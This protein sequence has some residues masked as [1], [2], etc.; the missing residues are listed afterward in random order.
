MSAFREKK[1]TGTYHLENFP[2]A[3]NFFWG[4]VT[5]FLKKKKIEKSSKTVTFF[6]LVYHFFLSKRILRTLACTIF[7]LVFLSF[8]PLHYTG[9][10]GGTEKSVISI[11]VRISFQPPKAKSQAVESGSRV[12]QN[13]FACCVDAFPVSL[14]RN[15]I[16]TPLYAFV[17]TFATLF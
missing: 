1:I 14:Y 3:D 17:T 6:S 9:S 15:T 7:V 11:I 12:E 10:E 4:D 2:N 16:G 5:Y 13:R 8:Q